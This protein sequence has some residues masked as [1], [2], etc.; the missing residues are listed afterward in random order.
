[1]MTWYPQEVNCF[2]DIFYAIRNLHEYLS[3]HVY[4]NQTIGCSKMIIFILFSNGAL[5]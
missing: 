4:Y 2:S 1:M 3:V 5:N